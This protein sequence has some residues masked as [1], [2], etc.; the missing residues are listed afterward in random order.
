MNIHTSERLKAIERSRLWYAENRHNPRV[1]ESR[2]ARLLAWRIKYPREYL[3]QGALGRSKTL[4]LP[5]NLIPE[6]IF[7][8]DKCPALLTS[9]E[10]GTQTA[11]SLDRIIPELGYIKGN[12]QVI[13]RKANLMKQNAT[14]K[15]LEN[16]AKWQLNIF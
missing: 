11:M 1:I 6:D 4:N 12:V 5:F 10:F 3:I 16:F 7:I 9:F 15:E 13:S 14:E 8:P 2:K